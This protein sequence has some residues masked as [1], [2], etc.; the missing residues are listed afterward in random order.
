MMPRGRMILQWRAGWCP[1]TD[2]NRRPIAYEAIAL[3]A[4]LLGLRVVRLNGRGAARKVKTVRSEGLDHEVS[5][6]GERA[7]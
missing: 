6:Q 1:K 7:Y 3:P 2:S 4:E 5:G